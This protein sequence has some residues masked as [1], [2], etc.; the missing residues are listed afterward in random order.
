M[1][2]LVLRT[3][4][5]VTNLDSSIYF[6]HIVLSKRVYESGC[7]RHQMKLGRCYWQLISSDGRVWLGTAI[8]SPDKYP[9]PRVRQ[10]CDA[11]MG[12]V[13]KQNIYSHFEL[14]FLWTA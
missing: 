11:A 4:H 7:I 9:S 1:A 5:K 12:H 2:C 14:V 8:D 6:H 13:H 3:S 10:H